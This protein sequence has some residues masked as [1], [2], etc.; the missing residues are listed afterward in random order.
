MNLD[1]G[2]C[3][4]PP[5]HIL[6]DDRERGS[7]AATALIEMPGIRG[8]FARLK[9]G[10]YRVDERLV[11]ERKTMIDL[12]HSIQDGRL[13][14]QSIALSNSGQPALL[15]IEGRGSDLATSRMTREAIQGALITISLILGLPV[16]RAFDGQETARLILF[17]AQ[18]VRRAIQGTMHR[19][20]LRPKGKRR[21][22]CH[23]LQGF[24]NIGP[25]RAERL[26]ERFGTIEAIV[27]A[28]EQELQSVAGIGKAS[29]RTFRWAVQESGVPYRIE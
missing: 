12:T 15:I 28:S 1:Q 17:A 20:G 22:Q 16:L 10:D 19:P 3:P 9:V 25:G 14:R 27:T 5:I 8:E 26:L 7:T 18:Q 2:M 13:F 24:P 21:L 11:V 29:A 4:D 23:I 6:I